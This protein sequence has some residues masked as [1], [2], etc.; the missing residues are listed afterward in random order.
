MAG[1]PLLLVPPFWLQ[2]LSLEHQ[3]SHPRTSNIVSK[4]F[5][6]DDLLIGA[7]SFPEVIQLSRE[8]LSILKTECF[9]L[10][11]WKSNSTEALKQL[12]PS[13][14]SQDSY[15]F[16]SSKVNKTL[17]M[18]WSCQSDTFH[19]SISSLN[20]LKPVTKRVILSEVSKIY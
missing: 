9:D 17:G 5:Y 10:C 20:L 16:C 4:D 19:F 12:D 13:E 14:S 18:L 6:M 1:K 2:Q 11:K 7:D 3:H 8:I 15:F